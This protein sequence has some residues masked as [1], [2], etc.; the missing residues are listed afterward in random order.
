MKYRE[1]LLRTISCD[2][3]DRLVIASGHVSEVREDDEPRE[4]TST[5]VDTDRRQTVSVHTVD[6]P[7]VVVC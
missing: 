2:V 7:C 3:V 6:M 1:R 5:R 4:E